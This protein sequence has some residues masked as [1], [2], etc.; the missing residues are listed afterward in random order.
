M[1]NEIYNHLDPI[2]FSIGPLD[3][4]WYGLAYSVGFLCF[5]FLTYRLAKRW[6]I[7]INVD[8]ILILVICVIAGIVIGARV[9]Y[10]FFYGKGYYLEHP[11][12]ILAFSGMSFH[13]G[14]IGV[15]IGGLVAAK[16][17]RIPFSTIADFGAIGAPLGLF[18]GRCANF[19]N[20]ELWGAPTDASWG[21]VFGGMA[22]SMPRHPTQ[23]YEAFLEGLVLFCIL[24]ILARKKPPLPR[25]TFIGFFLILYGIFRFAIEFV[26][27]PDVQLGYLWGGWFTMGMLL[28][29]PMVV[30]GVG[31][32]IYALRKKL[33][34]QGLPEVAPTE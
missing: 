27:E 16:I 10:I 17:T 28:S 21:V 32:V 15:L 14:L 31:V 2:I 25:G 26:R 18:F 22:G 5:A 13:G 11:E 8:A 3:I 24:F 30:V 23:L 1:L 19:I 4:R 29:L 9:G 12:M 33:P 6:Q 34:Q 20:G 7:K